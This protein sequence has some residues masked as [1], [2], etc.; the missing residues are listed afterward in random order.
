MGTDGG[1]YSY[2]DI[3]SLSGVKYYHLKMVDIDGSFEYSRIVSVN[4]LPETQ[5]LRVYPNPMQNDVSLESDDVVNAVSLIDSKGLTVFAKS[6]ENPD[7][8]LR[9][10]LPKLPSGEYF[11]KVESDSGKSRSRK[12]L[13][14]Q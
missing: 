9:L 7:K 12:V 1:A 6:Y 2:T 4:S 13:I 11:L 3:T 14:K 5:N 8:A 10:S